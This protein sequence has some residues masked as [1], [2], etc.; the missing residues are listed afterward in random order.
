M[1]FRLYGARRPDFIGRRANRSRQAARI[2]SF[3]RADHRIF[4]NN[5]IFRKPLAIQ[6]F[7]QPQAGISRENAGVD[8]HS[9]VARFQ[10]LAMVA[11]SVSPSRAPLLGRQ[12]LEILQR[13]FVLTRVPG[14]GNDRR[15]PK[16]NW[17]GLRQAAKG[18]RD[19]YKKTAPKHGHSP[20]KYRGFYFAL[21]WLSIA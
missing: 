11:F 1:S 12:R 8:Y 10:D 4:S 7:H 3:G 16:V 20:L 17:L 13:I 15:L 18:Y 19:K 2:C 21:Q 14:I 6:T 5:K 9:G